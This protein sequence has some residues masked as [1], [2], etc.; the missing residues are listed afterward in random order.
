MNKRQNLQCGR[1]SA[2]GGFGRGAVG[3]RG[4]PKFLGETRQTERIY[5]GVV[6]GE[7]GLWRTDI[8]PHTR[9]GEIFELR[10]ISCGVGF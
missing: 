10:V 5:R 2:A 6:N 1:G 3:K 8:S 7:L 4:I 9:A